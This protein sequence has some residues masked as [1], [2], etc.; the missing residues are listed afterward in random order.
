[1]S[2][3]LAPRRSIEAENRAANL[4]YTRNTVSNQGA[5][6]PRRE[7]RWLFPDCLIGAMPLSWCG[8]VRENSDQ[9]YCSPQLRGS[10]T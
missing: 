4:P 7:C 6:I 3:R 8:L 5:S 9:A 1:V 2:A 10:V